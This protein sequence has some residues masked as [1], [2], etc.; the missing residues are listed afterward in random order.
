MALFK[1]DLFQRH[2][3]SFNTK[4]PAPVAPKPLK[5]PRIVTAPVIDPV[6]PA[7]Q[8]LAPDPYAYTPVGRPINHDED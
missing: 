1:N 8:D 3:V 7:P 4:Q 5:P 6:V 2:D